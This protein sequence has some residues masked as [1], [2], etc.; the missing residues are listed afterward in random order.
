MTKHAI[1][2]VQPLDVSSYQLKL[3]LNLSEQAW[4]ELSSSLAKTAVSFQIEI[5]HSHG[6]IRYMHHS[7][8]GIIRLELDQAGEILLRGGSIENLMMQCL[9]NLVDFN[10]GLRRLLG[11]AWNDLFEPYHKVS[12]DVVALTRAI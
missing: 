11:T 7:S 8:L 5:Q 1:W 6:L 9:G 12:E 4:A 2:R 3:N 10:R